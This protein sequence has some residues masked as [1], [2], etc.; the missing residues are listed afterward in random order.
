MLQIESIDGNCQWDSSPR[1]GW[2]L[3]ALTQPESTTKTGFFY[4]CR[5]LVALVVVVCWCCR[6]RLSM[7]MM[8]VV[9]V[10]VVVDV[11]VRPTTERLRQAKDQ[12]RLARGEECARQCDTSSTD[13]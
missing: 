2:P 11:T 13:V 3:A 10:V 1:N 5:R 12:R 4:H 6:R 8:L 9:V 7:M